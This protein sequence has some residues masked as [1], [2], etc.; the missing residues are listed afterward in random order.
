MAL[1]TRVGHA[2]EE[3]GAEA[4]VRPRDVLGTTSL[5]REQANQRPAVLGEPARALLDA[6]GVARSG[7]AGSEIVAWGAAASETR[8]YLDGIEIARLFHPAGLRTTVHPALLERVT[9]TPGALPAAYGRGLGGAV[10]LDARRVAAGLRGELRVDA[11]DSSL[12][13]EGGDERIRGLVGLRYGYLDRVVHA[14]APASEQV[15]EVPGHADGAARVE[16]HATPHSVLRATWVGARSRTRLDHVRERR[17]RD[18]DDQLAVVQLE[19]RYP[20]GARARIAPFFGVSQRREQSALFGSELGLRQRS[21][22][23]GLRA[24][25]TRSFAWLALELGVDARVSHDQVTRAGTSSL[26]AR[27]GDV[28]TFGQAPSDDVERD[29]WQASIANVAP[30]SAL[31]FRWRALMLRAGLRLET[32]L[33]SVERVLPAI[34]GIPAFGHAGLSLYPEP[35]AAL[36]YRVSEWLELELRAGLQHQ[37]PSPLDLSATF[38]T[39]MLP[40]ARS[41]HGALATRATLPRWVTLELVAF[42]REL[43]KLPTRTELQ[44]PLI[45][46]HLTASGRGYARG[47]SLAVVGDLPQGLWF[48]VS[49]TLSRSMRRAPDGSLRPFDADQ[50]HVMA[51]IFGVT[52]GAFAAS[53][54]IRAAS[55][56]PATRVIG[57]Y[58][59]T[60]TGLM[61]PVFG[62][63]N[64]ARLPPYFSLDLHAEYTLRRGHVHSAFFFDVYNLTNHTN[65]ESYA[66][67]A[68]YAYRRDVLSLPVVAMAGLSVRLH[69]E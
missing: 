33:V 35:R 27:E 64:R 9:L 15:I 11:I 41:M 68:D 12:A 37:P 50:P 18:L 14:L 40:A 8:C 24:D 32:Y 4:R 20:D 21:F 58:L 23:Y 55:G 6:P 34:A 46:E 63:P 43:E 57:T 53:A 52:Y 56:A 49:Y 28:R 48:S 31:T 36:G 60:K 22:A 62:A 10:L 69:D 39:P 44:P 51:T 1:I 38:G 26:P 45:A 7:F 54:R 2:Q 59:D 25:Y 47:A 29:T 66:Y 65:L 13:A 5:S 17:A 16:L 30:F 19:R 42:D 67:S 3:Y 61:Q